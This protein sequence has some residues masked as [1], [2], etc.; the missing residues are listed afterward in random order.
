MARIITIVTAVFLLGPIFVPIIGAGIL[1]FAPWQ[2]VFAAS[3]L[4]SAAAFVV[5]AGVRRDAR[6][7]QRRPLQFAPARRRAPPRGHHPG[8]DRPHRRADLRRAR[9]SSSGSAA[10]SRSSTT[11]TTAVRSSRSGS[12][13]PGVVMALAL[14]AN[15][16]MIDRFGARRVAVAISI[17]FVAVVRGRHR[18]HAR[19]RRRAVDLD[20]LRL[21]GG[22]QRARHADHAAVHDAGARADG[23]ARRH[24]VGR[25]RLR[26]ARRG[27]A[28]SPR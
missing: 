5:D 11:S 1:L 27:S 25:A 7:E 9:R 15:G 12:R 22:R 18:G 16:R 14:L 21:G 13:R 3:L 17:A 8:D 26:V 28:C 23:C 4:A 20:V 6:P 19:H 24:C 2:G 10:L